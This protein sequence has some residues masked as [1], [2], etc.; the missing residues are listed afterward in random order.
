MNPQEE[1]T[2]LSGTSTFKVPEDRIM[3]DPL[4]KKS[5]NDL[6]INEDNT[7]SKTENLVSDNESI[8]NTEINS[9]FTIQIGVFTKSVKHKFNVEVQEKMINEKYYC[10]YGRYFSIE[11]AK[12]QLSILKNK[13]YS[14]AFITGMDRDKKVDPNII[15]NIL[16]NL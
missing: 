13:G 5:N 15:K 11:E 1:T 7:K 10:F 12:E 8:N 2:M 3:I 16:D 4:P 14:D 6:I 9:Y